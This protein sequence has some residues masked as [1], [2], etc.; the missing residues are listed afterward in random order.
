MNNFYCRNC[1]KRGH[2]YKECNNPRLSY[3]IIL[4]NNKKEIIM[5]ERKDSISYIE[6][7]KGTYDL[8]N[9]NYIQLLFDRMG[10]LEKDKL[11]KYTFEELWN[12]IWYKYND[13]KK[14]YDK[15]L[16]KYNK[17]NIE[18]YIKNCNKKYEFNEWEI[19]KGRRNLNE[20]NKEAAMREFKEETNINEDKYDLYDNILPIEESYTG[21]NNERYQN[22]YYIAKT[23]DENIEIKIDENN[24][25]QISEVKTI[26]WFNKENCVKHIRDYS[27]YKLKIIERI[28]KFL[29]GDY[30]D[31]LEK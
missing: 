25:D 22:V 7:I 15:C 24:T 3:G 27:D 30:L 16:K 8:E 17:I 13:N 29:N 6:F 11:T 14:E 28:F 12:D 9:N 5:I 18:E 19:P 2:K 4:F 1:G 31:I 21:C 10:S 26:S 23:N 20:N